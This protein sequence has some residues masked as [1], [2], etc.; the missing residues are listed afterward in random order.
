MPKA[1]ITPQEY[2]D[3]AL[4]K[5]GYSTKTYSTLRT[6]YYNEPT[7]LQRAS[8]DV[9]ILK[10]IIRD[11]DE[12]ALRDL[13][14]CGISPNACNKY[15]ESLLDKVCKSGLSKLLAVFLECGADVR[16][17]DGAGRTPLHNACWGSSKP[18]FE[19]FEMI[20]ELDLSMIFTKDCSGKTPL[21]YVRKGQHSIWIE[22]LKTVLDV[23]WPPLKGEKHELS[24]LMFLPAN[25][26]PMPNPE[27]ALPTK[28]CKMVAS[29]RMEPQLAVIANGDPS[30]DRDWD[31]ESSVCSLASAAGTGWEE[32]PWW[33]ASKSGS[34]LGS[35]IDDDE[36]EEDLFEFDGLKKLAGLEDLMGIMQQKQCQA[37][38]MAGARVHCSLPY[39]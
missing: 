9:H 4:L 38:L 33:D 35:E 23:Y 15:S 30:G 24:A 17:S 8:Y 36:E 27:C 19:T 37:S 1:A 34:A 2:L 39:E 11:K 25:S 20:L 5:R 29:G 12:E 13:L 22:Y 18:S 31:G 3:Q 10:V 26:H 6:A 7:K 16:V 28:L 14:S 21:A 32:A